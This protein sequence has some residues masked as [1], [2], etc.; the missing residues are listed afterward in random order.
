MESIVGNKSLLRHRMGI[1]QKTD[2]IK[3]TSGSHSNTFDSFTIHS[4]AIVMASA[5]INGTIFGVVNSFGVLYV[6]L[7]EMFKAKED[8]IQFL[9]PLIGNIF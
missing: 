5:T 4:C 8:K 9:E 3:T 7:I 2:E 1:P 6:Y